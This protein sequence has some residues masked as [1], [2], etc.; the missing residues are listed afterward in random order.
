M[1]EESPTTQEPRE[2]PLI[3]IGK[4]KEAIKDLPDDMPVYVCCE[5]FDTR[6]GSSRFVKSDLALPDTCLTHAA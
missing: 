6:P 3:T 4:L 1:S 2:R 5:G